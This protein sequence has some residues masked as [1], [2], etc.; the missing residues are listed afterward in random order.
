MQQSLQAIRCGRRLFATAAKHQVCGDPQ[1]VLQ[2]EAIDAIGKV[3]DDQVKIKFLASPINPSDINIVQGVYGLPT[4]VPAIGGNEGVAVVTEIGS[5]VNKLAVGDWVIPFHSGF[6]CW[7]TEALTVPAELIK[8]ANDIPPAYAATLSVNPATAYRLL[9]DFGDLKPGDVIMQNGANS[10]VGLAVIQMARMMGIKT[11]NIIRSDRPDADKVL[12]L[13][14][15]LGGDVNVLDTQVNTEGFNE[16]LAEL[17]PCKVAFNCVGGDAA[18]E[19]VRCLAPGGTVVTYGGMSKRPL[20]IPTDLIVYKQ[21]KLVGFWMAAW[22]A[23]RGAGEKERMITEIV[24]MI[25][26]KQLAFF[27]EIHDF[28]DFHHALD[29]SL[30]PYNFRKVVLN[31]DYPDR[32]Q[33]HD[34]RDPEDYFVFEADN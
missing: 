8:I 1:K 27:F 34:S 5:N 7:R 9:R 31:L 33:Q 32:L 23:E 30:E 3:G 18:T 21:L 15:N 26:S 28:D 20:T 13:L 2:L 4:K 12:R 10:M 29:T 22:Y 25:R 17:S 6:G 24:G 14:S 11:I 19:M 16:I